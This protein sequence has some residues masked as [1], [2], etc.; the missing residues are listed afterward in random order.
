MTSRVTFDAGLGTHYRTALVL[1]FVTAMAPAFSPGM[2]AQ[3]APAPQT[4]PSPNSEWV[5]AAGGHL[6]FDVVS[7]HP[8]KN[9][10]AP[11]NVNVPYGTEDTYTD[12]G[13]VFKATN[14]PV[15]RLM[16]FAFK[17]A[18][19]AFHDT[20]PD[21]AVNEG[22]NIEARSD[23]PHPTKDQMRLM[24]QSMLFERFGLKI[25]YEERTDPAYA[26]VLIKPGALGPGLR[27][28]PADDSCSGAAAAVRERPTT[29]V[30]ANPQSAPAAA[31]PPSYTLLPDGFPL[32]CGT[33]VRLPP[34]QPYMRHEGG[35]NLTM[36]QI[37]GTFSNM[38]NLGQPVVD[39]TGL[40]GTYDWVMEFIDE[41]DG[42]NPPN[43]AVGLNF[44]GAL[45][46]QLGMKLVSTKTSFESFVVD[47]IERPT[48]N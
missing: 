14:W 4:Q 12:T 33:Y 22:F 2:M 18:H 41:H 31:P 8:E 1:L 27:P 45:E 26:A 37:V 46:K 39:Q 23:N 19:N 40:T 21:W 6:E 30:E 47:H 17:D 10:D 16:R 7:I 34:S 15:F 42:M 44:T 24:V 20:L 28:H 13:G 11:S 25:H 3:T 5:A 32:R 36:A 29:D 38:G 48:E 9:P 43:D 35:R